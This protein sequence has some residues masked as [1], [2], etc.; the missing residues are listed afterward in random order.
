MHYQK[1]HPRVVKLE[2]DDESVVALKVA[3][4][5]EVAKCEA[6]VLS[7]LNQLDAPVPNLIAYDEAQGVLLLEY[8]NGRPLGLFKPEEL[9]PYY[10]LFMQSSE[11]LKELFESVSSQFTDLAV[12]VDKDKFRN[13]MKEIGE[14][15]SQKIEFPILAQQ[16]W[17]DI[18]ELVLSQPLSFGSRDYSPYNIILQGEKM[19]FLDFETVG[20][21]WQA[22]R[23]WQYTTIL[24]D[25]KGYCWHPVFHDLCFS[26]PILDAHYVLFAAMGI[27]RWKVHE[28]AGIS[29][30]KVWR[31]QSASFPALI[32]WRRAWNIDIN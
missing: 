23:F 5:H 7:T 19:Y 20:F 18:L 9:K 29:I 2:L 30:Q 10:H 26:D 28:R 25:E 32:S 21:D 13:E 8:L 24:R 15:L 31:N 12:N 14:Y 6:R 4:T 16:S 17:H 22:R 1:E 3:K 27:V 11:R